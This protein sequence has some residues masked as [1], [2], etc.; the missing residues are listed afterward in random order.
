MDHISGRS[1]P[2]RD[3]STW[4][5]GRVR[6]WAARLDDGQEL[7]AVRAV[8]VDHVQDGHLPPDERKSWAKLSLQ[9]N[10]R[11]YDKG[12]QRQ[13]RMTQNNVRLRTFIISKLGPDPED[14][15]WSPEQVVRDV[16]AAVPLTPE[17]ARGLSEHWRDLPVDRIR[18]LREIKNLT[19]PLQELL[20]HLHPGRLHAQAQEWLHAR[21][22]L[23]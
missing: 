23:P 21:T 19:G 13:A 2:P 14:P 9:V 22:A 20:G 3:P 1:E 16:L 12:A 5:L 18:E 15:D 8:T 17:Q 10:S 4:T 7:E 6:E 11:M